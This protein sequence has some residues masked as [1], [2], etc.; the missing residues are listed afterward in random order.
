MNSRFSEFADISKLSP[1]GP[2]R[3][4]SPFHYYKALSVLNERGKRGRARLSCELGIGEGSIRTLLNELEKASFITRNNS[5]IVLTRKAQKMV[6]SFPV[7]T[8]PVE[9]C[10][11]ALGRFTTAALA[12]KAAQRVTNGIL[13]R[14][15]AVR[16][17]AAGAT[18]LIIRK[19]RLLI[20]PVME[21]ISDKATETVVFGR[22]LGS[23]GDAV[24]LTSA[25]SPE[26]S[27]Q[28]AFFAALTVV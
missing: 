12:R 26:I 22:L 4:F 1:H 7:S 3:K 11:L 6:S 16:H 8:C 13:Q 20:P 14:D 2:E 5:G 21:S 10:G 17:G 25:E 9:G 27:E 24:I 19:G 23:D 28:A 15:E 18:T